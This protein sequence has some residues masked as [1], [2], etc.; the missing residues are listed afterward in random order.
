MGR[1]YTLHPLRQLREE[2]VSAQS[3]AVGE[4]QQAHERARAD[5]LE[6]RRRREAEQARAQTERQAERARL[7]AGEVRAA[8]LQQGERYW[9]GATERVAW[10]LQ[11]EVGAERQASAAADGERRARG[12]LAT[13]RADAE[14]LERHHA[15]FLA[16]E[17]R[18]AELAEEEA[19]L[20]RWTADRYGKARA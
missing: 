10:L 7:E 2:R 1:K 17:R 20:D 19:Q 6:A 8:D 15:R 4:A 5:A 14:A 18:S 9:V 16:E 3:R 12:E 13:A 11:H